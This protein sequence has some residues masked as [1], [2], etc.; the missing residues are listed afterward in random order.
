MVTYLY[1]T[2]KNNVIYINTAA[3]MKLLID[4]IIINSC[5]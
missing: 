3:Y 5:M 2:D 1:E 4:F